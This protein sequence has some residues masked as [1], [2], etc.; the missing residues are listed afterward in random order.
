MKLTLSEVVEKTSCVVFSEIEN[1]IFTGVAPLNMAQNSHISFLAN[2]KYLDD[3]LKT[4]AG[5]LFCSKKNSEILA[6]NNVTSILL[7]C[8]D[9]YAAFAKVAQTFFQPIH[10]FSG[11]SPQAVI[12]KSANIHASATIFPFVFVGPGAHIGA[13]SVIYSGCFIG[14][15]STIGED[16]ILYPNV[17]VREG[18]RIG[19]R[20]LFNPG[21][22][23][24]GDGFGFA[25]T[26]KENVKI[27]QIGGVQIADDV[28]LGSNATIDRGAL[29]DTKIGRQTK[30]DNLVLIAHN[31]QVGEFCFLAGQVGIAG[32]TVVGNRV[33]MGG[34]VG[35]TGH[36]KI[37]NNS[38]ITAQ[39]GVSKSLP[40]G[41][42]WGGSPGRPYK[43]YA[44]GVAIM[45]KMIKERIKKS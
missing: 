22:V 25:P 28:E 10:P 2:E 34:Q 17:V 19:N 38:N 35:V 14:A 27:P 31:V 33:F 20:C 44:L 40:E 13:N 16:C 15:A 43:E 11:I 4:K 12:D 32:S 23:V 8:D 24:G 6:Q 36:I 37:G 5:A 29:E 39:T 18:C 30:I 7:V 21:A 42:T 3:A 45:S 1:A 41:Q 26:E 9:P